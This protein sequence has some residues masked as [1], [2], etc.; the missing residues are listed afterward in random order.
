M[1]LEY[2][3][4]HK[5]EVVTVFYGRIESFWVCHL[6]PTAWTSVPQIHVL[7]LFTACSHT[8]GKDATKELV[9]YEKYT[10]PRFID[11]STIQASVGRVQMKKD[12]NIWAI[13]DRS[14]VYASTIISDL[15]P[16]DAI[17]Y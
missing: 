16:H 12:K 11:A 9:T 2:S 17:S 13:V 8:N 14:G 5:R 1:F 3:R 15:E 4:S 6:P 10:A 7:A